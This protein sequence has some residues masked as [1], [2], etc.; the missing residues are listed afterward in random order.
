MKSLHGSSRCLPK[1]SNT[2]NASAGSGR[3]SRAVMVIPPALWVGYHI[4]D[5][6]AL[7]RGSLPEVSRSTSNMR[8]A[9]NSRETEDR[10]FGAMI[11]TI[12]ATPPTINLS[13]VGTQDLVNMARGRGFQPTSIRSGCILP[14]A[15]PSAIHMDVPRER[16]LT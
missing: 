15:I 2:S 3:C 12:V 16:L 7:F 11:R 4:L 6:A 14:M 1:N 13:E 8:R 10:R 5:C 9:L